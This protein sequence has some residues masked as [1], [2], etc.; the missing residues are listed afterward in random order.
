MKLSSWT[1]PAIA[2]GLAPLIFS[3]SACVPLEEEVGRT[4]LEQVL[5]PPAA[6]VHGVDVSS[7]EPDTDW[8]PVKAAGID[9]A[10]IKATESTTYINPY[11]HQ[12]RAGA[13]AAGVIR[14]AYHF[15]RGNVDG[16]AQA[17]FFL[18]TIGSVQPDELPPVL[19]LETMD[20]ASPATVTARALAWLAH[21]KQA[22]GRTPM[23]YLSPGFINALGNPQEFAQYHLWVAHWGVSC[24]TLPAPWT[25]WK[26]W[27]HT[28]QAGGIPGIQNGQVDRNIFRG[29][30]ADL[31]VFA[32]GTP[33]VELTPQTNSNESLTI[34]NWPDKHVEI[35]ATSP[36][37]AALHSWAGG[38]S[39]DWAAP[40]ALDTGVT[41]GVAAV[42]W[43]VPGFYP[44]LFAPLANGA[45]GHLW[46]TGAAWNKLQDFGAPGLHLGHFSTIVWAAGTPEVFALGSDGAIYHNWWSKGANAWSGWSELVGDQPLSVKFATGPSSILWQD[47]HAEVFAT[48]ENGGAWHNWTGPPGTLATGWHGWQS[49]GGSLSSRPVPVRWADGHVEVFARGQDGHLQHSWFNQA[50]VTWEP[51][52]P[53]SV[54]TQIIG[55][56]SVMENK[57]GGGVI[58]GPEIFARS[59]QG[60]VVHLWWK[61]SQYADFEPLGN[62]VA[63]SDP[64]AWVRGDGRAEVFVVDEQ[65]GL[66]RSLRNGTSWSGWGLIGTGVAACAAPAAISP[67]VVDGGTVAPTG[68]SEDGGDVAPPASDG[69]GPGQEEGGVGVPEEVSVGGC[70]VGAH[71]PLRIRWLVLALGLSLVVR[72][73]R[74]VLSSRD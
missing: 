74:S 64:L 27:Q 30:L 14:G 11:Y 56:P 3:T 21:V 13:K 39:D 65:G 19:D 22:T 34:I 57:A 33:P 71:V 31:A 17:N 73:W 63:E 40:T 45:T 55:E 37:G 68:Q 36:G 43:N 38:A 24:P 29:S 41:C 62:Q 10:I 18:Q 52:T 15:F 8:P 4:Q 12:D 9:F 60:V 25:E 44:E 72:R 42:S 32:T 67:S 35:F 16:V 23:V 59:S 51:F 53:L 58:E 66:R 61:G 69:P 54:G 46:W 26:I 28:D 70:D 1:F 2:R 47:D 48:D 49:L 20:G 7:Y 5:C 6:V 50:T